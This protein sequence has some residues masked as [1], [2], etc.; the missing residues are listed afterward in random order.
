MRKIPIVIEEKFVVLAACEA[1]WNI[2]SVAWDHNSFWQSTYWWKVWGKEE[3]PIG[4][5]TNTFLFVRKFSIT[6]VLPH[7]R[8]NKYKLQYVC[9]SEYRSRRENYHL[10]TLPLHSTGI[11]VA[12]L[13]SGARRLLLC[14]RKEIA[15]Q[16]PV[17]FSSHLLT[18][19][20][21]LTTA[22]KPL[23]GQ[24]KLCQGYV[25]MQRSP[26]RR[27]LGCVLVLN[28]FFEVC[29]PVRCKVL[30]TTTSRQRASL[31]LLLW[32]CRTHYSDVYQTKAAK[33]D[34]INL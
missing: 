1:V 13:I 24:R 15:F 9:L 20:E 5:R 2:W 26:K 12:L 21:P 19:H 14:L 11:E 34:I 27:L 31:N 16:K 17:L 29:F 25:F 30:A 22:N 10:E 33:M 3:N 7:I 6:H 8:T 4:N 18:H 23:T 28:M 32:E